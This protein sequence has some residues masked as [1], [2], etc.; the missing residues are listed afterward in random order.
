MA[1]FTY[2]V[3]ENDRDLSI[4]ELL[5]RNFNFSSRFMT[6]LKQNRLIFL[7]G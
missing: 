2:I 4:K 7:N 6:K 3:N 1:K 5:S